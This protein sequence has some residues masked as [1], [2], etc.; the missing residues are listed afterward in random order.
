[1]SRVN[2]LRES[3]VWSRQEAADDHHQ[4]G[5]AMSSAEAPVPEWRHEQWAAHVDR[6]V[7]DDELVLSSG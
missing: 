3:K 2:P 5:L 6:D 4:G 7:S 1:M